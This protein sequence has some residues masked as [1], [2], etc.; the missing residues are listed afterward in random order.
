MAG[1]GILLGVNGFYE[2]SWGLSNT[3]EE[4]CSALTPLCRSGLVKHLFSLKTS[5]LIYPSFFRWNHGEMLAQIGLRSD[6]VGTSC[7]A[8]IYF[9]F[10]F[11]D[12]IYWLCN[13]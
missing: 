13:L 7:G 10:L 9:K 11:V 4:L 2:L 3:G 1:R 8:N 12:T 6:P 5:A